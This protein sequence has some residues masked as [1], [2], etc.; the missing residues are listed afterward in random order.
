MAE[1]NAQQTTGTV[2]HLGSYRLVEPLG[3]GG[4]SSVFRAVHE[5][6]GY[7]VA[8]KVLP[9][10]LAKQVDAAQPLPPR[11]RER[12]GAGAPEHR[13][14]LRPR[15]RGRPALPRPRVRRRLGPA[16]P[17]PPTRADGR[18]AGAIDCMLQ[19]TEGLKY[20][21]SKGV[22]HRDIK[23]ANLLMDVDGTVK[24]IDLGLALQNEAEDE[25]VTRDG[26]TVGTV[27]YMAPEQARDSRAATAAERHLLARLHLLLPAD[28]LP[29]VP[30]RRHRRE[31]P[32]PRPAAPARR[33]RPPARRPPAGRQ[34]DPPDDGQ[35]ARRPLRQL[36][37]AARRAPRAWSSSPARATARPPAPS[38]TP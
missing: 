24:L 33:P 36:R 29:A 13:L 20:A 3:S 7:D 26:T 27:D 22:I 19:A 4:M 38:S 9:R 5:G 12:R 21:A 34:A 1:P 23:P 37:R 8:V 17:G 18:A 6:T 2:T 10:Y 11:G 15:L 28:R 31:A 30:G 32:P 35:E 16:R 25:R 14:D